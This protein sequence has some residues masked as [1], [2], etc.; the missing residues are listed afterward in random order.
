[1]Q[2]G[3]HCDGRSL[4][5][6]ELR[7]EFRL[8]HAVVPYREVVELDDGGLIRWR[9]MEQRDWLRRLNAADLEDCHARAMRETGD[10]RG[11]NLSP[12]QQV[13]AD[14]ANDDGVLAG[15][16]VDADPALVQAVAY[17]LEKRGFGARKAAEDA[18][19]LAAME[20]P[21]GMEALGQVE[22]VQGERRDMTRAEKRLMKR[23]LKNDDKAKAKREREFEAQARSQGRGHAPEQEL[24]QARAPE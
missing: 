4:E 12:E 15:R 11:R 23:I 13:L 1:M 7:Y 10:G 21:R 8:G 17:E 24:G 5:Y 2:L 14:A 19:P 22:R 6:D 18:N 20:L 9:A 3:A 16:I